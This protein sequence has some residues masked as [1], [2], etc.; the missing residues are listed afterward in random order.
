MDGKSQQDMQGAKQ[1]V[2]RLLKFRPRSVGEIR[3]KL[4]AKNFDAS[5]IEQTVDY[6]KKQQL[7]DDRLFAR[8]WAASRLKKPWGIARIRRELRDKGVD[9]ESIN[10]AFAAQFGEYDEAQTVLDLAKRRAEK[11]RDNDVLTAKRR[12]YDY[13]CRRGFSAAAVSKT[14]RTIYRHDDNG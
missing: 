14:L 13:L 10:A 8:G 11:Y 9:A 4:A 5:T 2:F 7:L 12:L 3:E 1:S 6:F